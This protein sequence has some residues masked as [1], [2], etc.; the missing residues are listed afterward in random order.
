VERC[1]AVALIEIVWNLRGIL[2]EDVLSAFLAKIFPALS[3]G[4]TGAQSAVIRT[5][6]MS[7][8]LDARCSTRCR[9][10]LLIASAIPTK[11]PLLTSRIR[12]GHITSPSSSQHTA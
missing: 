12:T 11:P 2:D 7:R 3:Y 1:T 9:S 8:T 4:A 5:G 6:S 10:L